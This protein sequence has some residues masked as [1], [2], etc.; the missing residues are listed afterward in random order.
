MMMSKIHHSKQPCSFHTPILLIALLLFA[1][2]AFPA[3]AAGG[4]EFFYSVGLGGYSPASYGAPEA[5]ELSAGLEFLP[6]SPINPSAFVRLSVPMNPLDISMA[7]AWAG[8]ELSLGYYLR[9]PF[10]WV[11]PRRLAWTPSIG[12]AFSTRLGDLS[13]SGWVFSVSPVRLFTGRSYQSFGTIIFPFS[14]NLTS[15][16]W[17][18][19]LLEFSYLHR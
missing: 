15:K 6:K 4:P 9:H 2:A 14:M 11:S 5:L 1:C 18:I 7:R 16:G 8:A 17:G 13:D 12:A 3:G 10:A 19:R